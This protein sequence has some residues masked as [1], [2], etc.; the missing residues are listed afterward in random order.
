MGLPLARVGLEADPLS[1]C[2]HAGL[3]KAALS[4]IPVETDRKDAR[5]IAQRV[6]MSSYR[7]GSENL[8]SGISGVSA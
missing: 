4:A 3:V 6:R 2:L 5:G 7:A 8:D 1:R